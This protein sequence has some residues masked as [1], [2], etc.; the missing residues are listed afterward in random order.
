MLSTHFVACWAYIY[1]LTTTI[2]GKS[3][4]VHAAYNVSMRVVNAYAYIRPF[5]QMGS[6]SF[7]RDDVL[8]TI[9]GLSQQENMTKP[10]YNFIGFHLNQQNGTVWPD[11]YLPSV[12]M[13][14]VAYAQAVLLPDNDRVLLFGGY[15]DDL[16][17]KNR[18]LLVYE[19]RFGT[20]AWRALKVTAAYNA[21]KNGT[22]PKNRYKH[23]AT[24]AT[25][26]KIY[27][28]GGQIPGTT[29]RFFVDFWEYDPVTGR[30][31]EVPIN[32][33]PMSTIQITAVALPWVQKINH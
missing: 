3:L 20:R 28:Y 4:V 27:I 19:F 30:F 9:G 6:A 15:N 11:R 25:N 10:T 16:L 17:D 29:T 5:S 24:L 12:G 7:V 1:L 21:T 32:H 13:P 14:G 2:F 31:T 8:Y 22:V 26:G 18:T 33:E 23:T